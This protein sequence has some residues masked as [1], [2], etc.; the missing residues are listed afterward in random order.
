MNQDAV[1]SAVGKPDAEL[2]LWPPG[3]MGEPP[4]GKRFVYRL[5]L[6]RCVVWVDLD[7][8]GNVSEVFWRERD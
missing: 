1:L 4:V 3:R 8:Q 7:A 5:E 6:G 2:N